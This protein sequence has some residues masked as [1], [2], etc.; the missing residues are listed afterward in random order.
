MRIAIVGASNDRSKFGN[1][2]VRAYLRAGH[3][4]LPINPHER[5]VEGLQTWPTV[6]QVPGPLDRIAMYVPP[7]IG[8]T[9]IPELAQRSDIGE[10]WFNPGSET[11]ELLAE[12]RRLGLSIVFGCAILDIGERP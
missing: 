3:E 12:A 7:R 4:V 1:R 5:E 9:I 11:P 6:T 8:E 2:A 10:L